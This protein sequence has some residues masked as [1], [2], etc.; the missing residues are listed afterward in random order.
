MRRLVFAFTIACFAAAPS[1]AFAGGKE[2]FGELKCT[3]CHTVKS[4]GIAAAGEE[5]DKIV[6]ISGTGKNHDVEWF[7]KWL[8]KEVEM[9]SKVKT[10]EKVKHKQKF[11]GTPEQLTEITGWLKTLTK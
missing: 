6:D 4:E 3:K 11:K 9:E 2:L 5:K 8:N 7:K 10:G 1:A